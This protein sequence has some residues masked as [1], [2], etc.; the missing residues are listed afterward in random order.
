MWHRMIL[1]PVAAALAL[2]ACEKVPTEVTPDALDGP[3]EA[4]TQASA[5]ALDYGELGPGMDFRASLASTPACQGAVFFTP[6][7]VPT[8]GM[9]SPAFGPVVHT[10]TSEYDA[11]GVHFSAGP[12]APNTPTAI[13]SDP[14]LAWGGVNGSGIVD[15]LASVDGMLVMPGTGGL[16]AQVSCLTVEGGFAGVG[17]L[18]LE[19]FDCD[20]NLVASTVNDDGIGPTGRALMTLNLAAGPGIAAFRVSTPAPGGFADTYGVDSIDMDAPS[21]CVIPVDVDIKPGSWPNSINTKNQG[22]IPVAI[23]GTDVFDVT[24]VDVST[25]AFGPG[26]AAPVHDPAGHYEDVN[27]DGFTDL[28]SHYPTQ[29]TGL[30]VG[31]TEACI[32]G[33]TLDGIPIEG[34]DAV[35]IVK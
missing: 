26:G 33:E 28:V 7:S 32:T 15:L 24:N 6:S 17:N 13:Y 11:F 14:P 34:C 1:V 23:L 25:L 8:A 27:V 30:Q 21:P 3:S 31:D 9:V 5:S 22:A 35:R 12:P 18:L 2:A 29:E 10:F 4:S 20:G 16:A 19:A